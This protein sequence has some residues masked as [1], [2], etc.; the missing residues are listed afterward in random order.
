MRTSPS[1][2]PSWG[3]ETRLTDGGG[4]ESTCRILITPHGDRK[5][6][7]VEPRA[8]APGTLITPH[9]DRKPARRA[10]AVAFAIRISLP[11]MG[12]G[13]MSDQARDVGAK[14]SSSHYP[15]WGS[16]TGTSAASAAAR[17]PY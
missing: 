17:P 16:E 12:I 2:Y 3:S 8:G 10:D 13:N 1:H 11:L 6:A 5:P 9:G 7:R 14:N 15:S 4:E